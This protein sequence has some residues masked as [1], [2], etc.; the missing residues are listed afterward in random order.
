MI[1]KN[2][3]FAEVTFTLL[4]SA[5]IMV[6]FKEAPVLLLSFRTTTATDLHRP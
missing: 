4:T 5:S 1:N 2:G 6:T 3:V